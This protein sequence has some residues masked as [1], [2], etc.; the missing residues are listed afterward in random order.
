MQKNRFPVG[1]QSSENL[2]DKK[3]AQKWYIFN[4]ICMCTLAKRPRNQILRL[5]N[6]FLGQ[7]TPFYFNTSKK[8]SELGRTI[9]NAT[10]HKDIFSGLD[11]CA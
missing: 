7:N 2:R 3:K 11:N 1:G 6:D 10:L 8:I 9:S 5:L 4:P